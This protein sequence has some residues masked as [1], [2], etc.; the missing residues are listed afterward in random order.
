MKT[1]ILRVCAALG[2][3]AAASTALL[4]ETLTYSTRLPES[5]ASQKALKATDSIITN[6]GTSNWSAIENAGSSVRVETVSSVPFYL[7]AANSNTLTIANGSSNNWSTK[8]TTLTPAYL[9]LS[10]NSVNLTGAAVALTPTGS[11]SITGTGGVNFSS[12]LTVSGTISASGPNFATCGTSKVLTN[13]SGCS[14]A[15]QTSAC[16]YTTTTCTKVTTTTYQSDV[17]KTYEGS[18]DPYDAVKVGTLPQRPDRVVSIISTTT[19]ARCNDWASRG[20][21]LNS[22]AGHL[23][24]LAWSGSSSVDCNLYYASVPLGKHPACVATQVWSATTN[25]SQPYCTCIG[26]ITKYYNCD[27]TTCALDKAATCTKSTSVRGYYYDCDGTC[28]KNFAQSCPRYYNCSGTC[29]STLTSPATCTS[30]GT[31]GNVIGK[32]LIAY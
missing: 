6:Y 9:T 17:C 27:K 30:S 3:L 19:L 16:T 22:N 18:I 31:G 8:T 7:S 28:G 5:Y 21:Y 24:T 10:G 23:E 14:S 29:D 1:N 20:S 4:A 12:N 26:K 11:A 13:G 32:G 15:S 2:L 25:K